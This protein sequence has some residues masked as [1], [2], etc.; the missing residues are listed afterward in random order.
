MLQLAVDTAVETVQQFCGKISQTMGSGAEAFQL[1]G[2]VNNTQMLDVHRFN[3]MAAM[4]WHI[5][6]TM[7]SALLAANQ[8]LADQS[9]T[10][11]SCVPT[12]CLHRV[13]CK[14]GVD[15]V[16]IRIVRHFCAL[17]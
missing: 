4:H 12:A 3:A 11:F 1:S 15:C 17:L 10:C 7:R 9:R 2:H 6:N 16:L 5:G 13:T 8:E 14:G